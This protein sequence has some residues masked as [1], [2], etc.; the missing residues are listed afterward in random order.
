MSAAS[1]NWRR[2]QVD[3]IHRVHD[4]DASLKFMAPDARTARRWALRKMAEPAAWVDVRA[5]STPNG[6]TS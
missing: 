4:W 3:L 2:Y 1:R 6:G 5:A